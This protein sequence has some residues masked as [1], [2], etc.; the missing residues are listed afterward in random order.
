MTQ[1]KGFEDPVHP[2]F[3]CKLHKS[4]YGLK[5]APR[6][7]F[8]RLSTALLALGFQ[9]SQIDPSLFTHHLENIHVFLLVYVDDILVT[10]N[11]RDFITFLISKLQLEFA[12][13]D[14]GQLTY[15]LGIEA[16]RNSSG[17]H[18]WQTRY[19]IDLLD[20]VQLLGIRPY[21]AP[22][23]SG[24]KLSKFDGEILQDPSEYRQTV[25][26][27]QYVTLTRPDIAYSV[28]QLCQYMQAPT[29]VHWTAA[30]RV[31][32]YLKHTLDYG[33][34]YKS[35][36]FAINAYC[37]SDWAGDPDDRRSTCGYGVYVGSNLISWSAKKQPVVSKSSTEAEYRCLAL[38]TA[39]VYWLRMLLRELKVSLA[40]APVAWC[41]NVSSLALAS[42]PIFH[43]QSKHIEV[44][45]HF[46]REK[47]ANKDI[48]L[49]HVPTSLQPADIFT[50]GHRADR[51]CFLRDKLSVI[52]LPASLRGNDKD[53]AQ[54]VTTNIQNN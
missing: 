37:D 54:T 42:N 26:A 34:F 4:L 30:K 11:D 40:S 51:F 52:D 50:K 6:A 36:S 15:F 20:R 14:L 1:P 5:Q 32:R 43:A 13:K 25:G 44:D 23:V 46:V 28:N 10:S 49:Q 38:V 16:T 29:T 31:L 33:L 22:C 3:V 21:R 7:W 18:L 17:L 47:V 24:S 48:I 8:N 41:D 12:M 35:G 39:E 45:Y 53:K 9:S 19:I 27:L 2:Q